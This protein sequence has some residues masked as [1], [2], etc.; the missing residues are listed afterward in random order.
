MESTNVDQIASAHNWTDPQPIGPMI[1]MFAEKI[2][3]FP[4]G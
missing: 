2:P 4:A 1:P 3:E